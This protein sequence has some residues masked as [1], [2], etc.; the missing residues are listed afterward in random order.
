MLKKW[1]IGTFIIILTLLGI[2]S[3][4]PAVIANQEI[5]LQ[6]TDV[7]VTI[8][9]VKNTIAIV[10]KQLQDLGVDNIQVKEGELGKLKITYYSDADVTLIKETFSKEKKVEIDF[11]ANHNKNS[12]QL[13]LGEDTI[14]YNLDIYEIQDGNDTDWDLNGISVIQFDTKSDRFFDPNPHILF[15]TIIVSNDNKIV[16]LT[17]KVRRNIAIT[18]D[19]ILHKIPEVR[20]GPIC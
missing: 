13:P 14:S 18:I 8:D 19:D 10:K 7:A 9:E 3:Q 2:V 15:N 16:K 1:Y 20:A 12:N 6:F 5:V 4:R 17:Y 11:T